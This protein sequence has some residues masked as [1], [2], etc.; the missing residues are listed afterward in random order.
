MY[1]LKSFRFFILFVIFFG[2]VHSQGIT[3]SESMAR[4]YDASQS[5]LIAEKQSE[6]A[7]V[8]RKE[9]NAMWYPTLTAT[10]S[11]TYMSNDI[12]VRQEYTSLL[13]PF[14]SFFDKNF[15]TQEL[16]NIIYNF[17]GDKTFTVKI[18]D[19]NWATADLV[20]LYPIFM[21]GKRLY[22]QA[23]GKELENIG[24]LGEEQA[25]LSV[26][27]SWVEVY[28]GYQLSRESVEVRK[29]KYESLKGHYNQVLQFQKNGVATDMD[30]LLTKVAMDE[31]E[32]EWKEAENTSQALQYALCRMLGN[33]SL[34]GAVPLSPLFVCEHIPS[35]EWFLNLSSQSPVLA[36]LQ[37]KSVISEKNKNLAISDY[38]PNVAVF[39]KQTVASYNVSENLMPRTLVGVTATWNIFDGLARERR[40]KQRKLEIEVSESQHKEA[41]R[42]LAVAISNAYYSL[43]NAATTVKALD[44][45]LVMTQELVRTREVAYKEGMATAADVVDAQTTNARISL[46]KLAAYYQYDLMLAT[47]LSLCGETSYFEKWNK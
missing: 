32:R 13:T 20:L 14:N 9:I 4:V 36:A 21:G 3:F 44:S 33:D 38:F 46:L 25:R 31:A 35:K 30:C 29:A 45:T 12:E 15:I 37:A 27:L 34:C 2:N 40:I 11:Y 7:S 26:F 28:Y 41:E 17:L 47:L 19:Q 39:G 23:I 8:L 22:A 16:G 6:R 43:E 24:V 5:I 1:M 10:G 42:Q 18:Q